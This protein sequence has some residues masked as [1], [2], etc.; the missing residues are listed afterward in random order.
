MKYFRVKPYEN[1]LNY[2]PGSNQSSGAIV[3]GEVFSSESPDERQLHKLDEITEEE[4]I[5]A[6]GAGEADSS[7]VEQKPV[8]HNDQPNTD[9]QKQ[10]ESSDAKELAKQKLREGSK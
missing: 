2:Y 6:T 5:Q 7:E 1:Y 4:F 3:S 9:G 8:K 10:K